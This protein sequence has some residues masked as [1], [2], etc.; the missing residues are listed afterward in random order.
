[1][2]NKITVVVAH[3]DDEALGLGGTLI[4]HIEK[5]DK[6][7][8]I[9]LSL[10]EGAKSKE[11]KTLTREKNAKDWSSF[12]G[13]NL[14]KIFDYPDQKFDTAPILNIIKDIE[15]LFAILMILLGCGIFAFCINNIGQII[16][17]DS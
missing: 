16:S 11:D 9:I 12:V 1:M 15:K 7:N 4:K 6:V 8:I 2:N 5:G 17:K 3:P 13:S 10:G 14:F